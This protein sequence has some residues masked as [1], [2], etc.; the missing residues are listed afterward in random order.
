M[1]AALETLFLPA[2]RT[3]LGGDADLRGGP[4]TAPAA[5]QPARLSLWAERLVRDGP[6]GDDPTRDPVQAAW[7]GLVSAAPSAPLDFPLPEAAH[8]DV[9]EVQSPPGHLLPPGDAWQLDGRTLR[10]FRA[11]AG[12]VRVSTRS[13]PVRGYRER[14]P[15]RVE[16]S[17]RVWAADG[18]A[19]DALLARGLAALLAAAED[20]NVLE[21]AG[22]AP[23]LTVRLTRPRLSLAALEQAVDGPWIVGC[24]RCV[25]R[26]E[27]DLALRLGEAAPEG[28]IQDV[29]IT[30]RRP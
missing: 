5:G 13:E 29:A 2:L 4:A 11:P 18:A 21:L 9:A 28:R 16:L 14:R 25:L 24:A 27:V 23:T 22:Q 20:F 8:G 10:F 15:G 3:A 12:P 19:A 1:L 26:G 30:L 6:E 7:E 17:L